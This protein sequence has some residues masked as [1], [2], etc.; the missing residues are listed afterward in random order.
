MMTAA[1]P[2]STDIVVLGSGAAGLT[3]ALTASLAGLRAII[4]EHCAEVGGTS[5]RS[6]GTVWVPG[7]HYLPPSAVDSDLEQ[8]ARYLE[9]LVGNRGE[10]AIWEAFLEHAPRMT[11]D[12][13]EHADIAF[14]PY[15][16]FPDYRQDCPGAGAGGRP[17][18][19]MPFD[20]RRL[21]ADFARVSWPL[22]EL[23]VFGG[24]MITRGEA[25][26]L[27]R[28]DRSPRSLWLG[29]RLVARYARDR[30][31]YKRGTRLV[32][33]NAL[34]ARLFRAVLDRG[35][36]VLFE[37]RATR[38][39]EAGG[40]IGGVELV[41]DGRT[42]AIEARCGVILAGGGFPSDARWRAEHLPQ[43]VAE[44]T[45]AHPGCD[46]STIALALRAGA[47]L[48]PP[49]L[50]NALWFPSSVAKRADGS[51][52]VYPHI[53][54]DRAKPGL[55]AVNAAGERFVDEAVSYHE[56][57][58]AMYRTHERSPAIPAWLICDRS[59][60]RRYGLGLIRPRSMTLR[61]HVASGYLRT[62][63]TIE[64]LARGLGLP[65]KALAAT[66]SRFNG[67][68]SR[69]VDEDYGKG[70]NVY[71]RSNGDPAVEPNP[72]LGRIQ[73]P[74]FYAVEVWPTPLGTSRGLRADVN[75]RVLTESGEPIAGLY[76]CGNDMQS[77]FGGE[78]P[79][80]GGQ[81][82]QGMTFAWIAA[83]HAAASRR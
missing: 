10:R 74:P 60:I 6:S 16:V 70:G 61:K 63:P 23:M 24:M 56:F 43:P 41:H 15:T 66:V 50:D 18:E 68:A 19:P 21:G 55:I 5:A 82:G 48:G 69:G 76:V 80:A 59:F 38:L 29:L 64:E 58:R 13:A 45:P 49:G 57:V 46:G 65:P 33:G 30:L 34:V 44:H 47:A 51:T 37:A 20:G 67:F 3:A 40:R 77:A 62:A 2:T 28:A 11:R 14:R 25:R 26:D 27:L 12:L 32:L 36:P 73:T 42:V 22:P 4:V 7:N 72:C 8:A 83:R 54:L 1:T 31:G 52:A 71:D 9:T 79:G 17:L 35:V 78:Y 75:A 39:I 81:L 53:V